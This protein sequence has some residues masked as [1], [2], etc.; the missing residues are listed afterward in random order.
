MR[1]ASICFPSKFALWIEQNLAYKNILSA[2]TK[3]LHNLFRYIRVTCHSYGIQYI[4]NNNCI[5]R[6]YIFSILN[7]GSTVLC[8]FLVLAASLYKW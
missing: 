3:C 8:E 1:Y 7:G 4:N 2:N 6:Y 5:K